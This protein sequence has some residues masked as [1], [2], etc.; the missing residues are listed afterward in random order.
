MAVTIAL[1]FWARV[2]IK[3]KAFLVF[4]VALMFFALVFGGEHY[5]F[6]AVLGAGYAV[7][8]EFGCRAWERWRG[9]SLKTPAN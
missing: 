3:M 1:F 6:D 7:A 2:G 5:I 9:S 8:V 4:Y